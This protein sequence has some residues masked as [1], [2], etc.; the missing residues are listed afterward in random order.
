MKQEL[1]IIR[2]SEIALKAKATRT[3][4]EKKLIKNIKNAL[5][6]KQIS[7]IVKKEYGRIYIHTSQINE[8]IATLKKIFGI[9]SVSPAFQ[10]KSKIGSMS[11]LSINILK[12][13]L[14]NEKT[15]ALRVTRTGKHDFT[16]QDAA[17]KIG[18]EIVK[19]TNANVDLTKPDI[20]LFIEIRNENAYIFTERIRGAGGLP[21][22]TQGKVLALIDKP[23]SILAAWYL[24][25]RG[26]RTVFVNT[27]EFNKEFLQSFITNW[28][29]NSDIF[30][31]NPNEKNFYENLKNMAIELN[32]D[33][34]ITAYTHHDGYQ[35]ML[36]NVKLLKKYIKLPILC[37][38]IAMDEDEIKQ[39][40]KD[41]GI[42]L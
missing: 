31:I 34:L 28:Y 38:L 9:V 40:C 6:K 33:A 22:G 26:C 12:E 17:I 20:E 15:F 5:K 27:D 39:K 4:F 37:P 23:K 7:N 25:R 16:S 35:N 14:T 18:N 32:C 11:Q 1:I 13:K 3:Y 36:A 2:Y 8:S 10:T 41:V 21:L 30:S 29:A 24:M 42:K 19:A